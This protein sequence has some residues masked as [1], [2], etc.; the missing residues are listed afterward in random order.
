MVAYVFDKIL[1]DGVRAGQ[2][3]GRTQT[4]RDWFRDTAKNTRTTPES[5]M[6]GDKTRYTNRTMLGKMYMFFYDPKHKKTLKTYDTFPLIFPISR[7]SDGFVG[8]NFHYL[9]LKE[10]AVL[11]DALYELTN[12]NKFDDKTKL[13]LTFEMLN[14]SAKYKYFK[15]TVHRYLSAHVRSRFL[16]IAS[17]EWDTALFLPVERFEKQGKRTVWADSRK[18]V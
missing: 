6:R 15:P 16:E 9:G 7:L 18:S 13:R 11:M 14:K 10:R 17:A 1:S 5:I 4:A 3:P 12:N 8:M 2:L